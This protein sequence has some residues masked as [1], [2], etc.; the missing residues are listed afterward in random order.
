MTTGQHNGRLSLDRVVAELGGQR[1]LRWGRINTMQEQLEICQQMAVVRS[2]GLA[3]ARGLGHEVERLTD[4]REHVRAHPIPVVL[5]AAA[6][7]YW[8]VPAKSKREVHRLRPLARERSQN[9]QDEHRQ[10]HRVNEEEPVLETREVKKAGVAGMS[11]AV[12]GFVG[13]MIGNAV[14]SYVA[15]QMHT[16]IQ[17][18]S[19]H[20]SS[21]QR[22]TSSYGS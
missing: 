15:E 9:G 18:H 20:A 3:N 12:M 13:S 4:W 10:S 11:G 5:A 1:I 2:R 8:I 17:G 19:N 22:Q 6:L 16:L 14:R 7:G 21:N